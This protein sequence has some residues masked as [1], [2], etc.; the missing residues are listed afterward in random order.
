MVIKTIPSKQMLHTTLLFICRSVVVLADEQYKCHKPTLGACC[1]WTVYLPCLP[2]PGGLLGAFG[3]TRASASFTCD[4]ARL[5]FG[6][7]PDVSRFVK[8]S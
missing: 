2:I 1:D 7:F 8:L 3:G 6:N 5:E 4:C